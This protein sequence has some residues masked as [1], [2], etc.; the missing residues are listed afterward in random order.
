MNSILRLDT[1]F[2]VKPTV[3]LSKLGRVG[4]NF[5]KPSSEPA[6]RSIPA[7]GSALEQPSPHSLCIPSIAS[8]G[9]LLPPC[10]Y[11]LGGVYNGFRCSSCTLPVL[12][13][14]SV[15]RGRRSPGSGRA[16]LEVAR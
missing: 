16:P 7:G 15:R 4:G 13:D 12:A 6:T 1:P 2:P 9:S 14:Y 11:S 3:R 10:P 5:P 8:G